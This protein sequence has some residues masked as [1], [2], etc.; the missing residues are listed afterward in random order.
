M[1]YTHDQL[2]G[3]QT[4]RT[5]KPDGWLHV[6]APLDR[7]GHVAARSRVVRVLEE[8]RERRAAP[9]TTVRRC[10]R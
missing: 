4:F 7:A 5:A 1:D 9:A 10:R 6:G 8:L 3:A 2:A